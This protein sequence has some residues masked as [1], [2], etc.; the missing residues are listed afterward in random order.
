MG[1]CRYCEPGIEGGEAEEVRLLDLRCFRKNAEK[2]SNK[3]RLGVL[4]CPMRRLLLTRISPFK[5]GF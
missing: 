5:H 4:E 1:N 3:K 2:E